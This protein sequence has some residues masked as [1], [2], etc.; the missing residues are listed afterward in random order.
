[1]VMAAL[2]SPSV[3]RPA[4]LDVMQGHKKVQLQVSM[5]SPLMFQLAI[6][7]PLS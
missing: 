7:I 2:Q 1:M 6:V 4:K 3:G 5:Y